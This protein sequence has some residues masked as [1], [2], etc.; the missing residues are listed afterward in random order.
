MAFKMLSAAKLGILDHDACGDGI[1]D[2]DL[3]PF[4]TSGLTG[5]DRRA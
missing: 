4:D 2:N 5:N 1:S 3:A